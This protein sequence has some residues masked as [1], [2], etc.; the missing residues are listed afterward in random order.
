MGTSTIFKRHNDLGCSLASMSK[1]ELEKLDRLSPW[2]EKH[3]SVGGWSAVLELHNG[4]FNPLIW[5]RGKLFRLQDAPKRLTGKYYNSYTG[6]Y[7]PASEWTLL[8]KYLERELKELDREYKC[9]RARRYREAKKNKVLR[10][11][12]MKRV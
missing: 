10:T 1:E 4:N 9:A 6:K 5:W 7:L 3:E 8:K 12:G 11:G 2:G